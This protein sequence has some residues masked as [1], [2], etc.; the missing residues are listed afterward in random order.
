[1]DAVNAIIAL[2]N[3]SSDDVLY[4]LGCGDGRICMAASLKHN[5]RTVGV[6]IEEGSSKRLPFA[7]TKTTEVVI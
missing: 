3:L 6:E 4:D 7:C 2:A 5:V 1:M